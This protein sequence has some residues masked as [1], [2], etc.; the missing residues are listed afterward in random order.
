MLDDHIDRILYNRY[1]QSDDWASWY[2]WITVTKYIE[3][4]SFYCWVYRECAIA[5]CET[6]NEL[7][8]VYLDSWA[9]SD[10]W[11]I[12]QRRNLFN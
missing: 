10:M 6:C 9:F 11:R 1:F 4:Y 12:L 7:V 2:V 8:H 5:N 3:K